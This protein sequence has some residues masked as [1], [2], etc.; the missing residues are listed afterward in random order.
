MEPL[1]PPVFRLIK[2]RISAR[3]GRGLRHADNSCPPGS[4]VASRVCEHS[5]CRASSYF[6]ESLY[7]FHGVRIISKRLIYCIIPGVEDRDNRGNGVPSRPVNSIYFL[8]CLTAWGAWW[9]RLY[10]I[11]G[12]TRGTERKGRTRPSRRSRPARFSST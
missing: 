4:A 10:P 2:N 9:C 8:G 3:D 12:H 11:N 1:N 7:T 5:L 6:Y